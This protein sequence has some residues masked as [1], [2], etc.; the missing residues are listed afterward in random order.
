MDKLSNNDLMKE[1]VYIIREYK[2]KTLKFMEVCGTHTMSIFK[3]GIREMLPENIK[4]IS[5]PGCPVCVTA[6]G[7]IDQAI[8][9]AR[10][11]AIIVTFGDMVRVPGNG[12]SLEKEKAL[13]C[14]VRVI[15]SPLDTIKI[16]KENPN[17][18][19]V[20][21]AV[22]FETTS[23]VIA[24]MIKKAKDEGLENLFALCGMKLVLPALEMLCNAEIHIDGFLLPGHVSAVIG[25][26]SYGFLTKYK[27]ACVIGGF[28]AYDILI[29]IAM[30]IKQV[31]AEKYQ[32]ENAYK[33]IV[34]SEGNRKAYDMI[35]E[36][37]GPE[38][39]IWRGIGEIKE[40]GLKVRKEYR[41]FDAKEHF[42]LGEIYE[43]TP[44]GCSCGD[45]IKGVKTPFECKLFDKVCT[46]L[47]PV[48]A[49]MVSSEGTCAAYYKYGRK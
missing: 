30:L 6:Q 11:G 45:V 20:F 44:V 28:E 41:K 4:L 27:K 46:P 10:R 37:F 34:S 9:I 25:T 47:N 36:V 7:Y 14:D 3:H 21:L 33:R 1:L 13:G 39:S 35:F 32:V 26:E 8:E 24:L 17:R 49:C 29:S 5:G 43:S 38:D 16:A 42:S 15:Y 2:G 22:G 31:E 23:P 19:V 12:N 18:D 40:S 48:G